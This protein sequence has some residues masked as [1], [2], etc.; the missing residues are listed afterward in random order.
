MVSLSAIRWGLGSGSRHVPI[1]GDGVS[2]LSQL[3]A[4][5]V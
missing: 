4:T 5:P 1:A 3:V 2:G